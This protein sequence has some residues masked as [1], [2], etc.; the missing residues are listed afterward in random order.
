[1]T[2]SVTKRHDYRA[3]DDVPARN[4]LQQLVEVPALVR[5]L[6]LPV[7][8]RV[9][10]I[11]CGRGIALPVLHALLEPSLLLGLDLDRGLLAHAARRGGGASPLLL[12]ADARCI[13]LPDATVDLVIDFG[14]CYHIR[15]PVAALREVARVLRPGGVFV[16]ETPV[17]QLLAHPVRSFGRTLPWREVPA[18][19]RRRTAVLWSSREKRS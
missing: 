1:V 9:M 6:R 19:R 4:G 14:T 10:E 2:A 5:A 3:F 8:G 15:D 13:P 18:L 16:H 11:G 12:C 7:G 17:S